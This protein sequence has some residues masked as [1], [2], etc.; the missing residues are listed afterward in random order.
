ML[1]RLVVSTKRPIFVLRMQH[2]LFFN[3]PEN[4]LFGFNLLVPDKLSR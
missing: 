2:N 3:D 1:K 4:I